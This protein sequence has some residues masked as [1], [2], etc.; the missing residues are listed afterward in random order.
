MKK[1]DSDNLHDMSS[2]TALKIFKDFALYVKD[3][4]FLGRTVEFQES[5]PWN[6][7]AILIALLRLSSTYNE[8]AE[9]FSKLILILNKHIP[10][11]DGYEELLK[12][13]EATDSEKYRSS[14]D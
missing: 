5:L 2:E 4:E 11:P 13:K 10:A 9:D 1:L 12:L 3:D 14:L 8:R 7:E 6:K